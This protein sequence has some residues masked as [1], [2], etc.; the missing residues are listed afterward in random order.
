MKKALFVSNRLEQ[1]YPSQLQ[2]QVAELVDVIA[3]F[4]K[5]DI[6]DRAPELLSEVN[7][8]M[9]GWGAPHL[10][11]RFLDAAPNLEAF[12][13]AGGLFCPEVWPS[14]V[15]VCSAIHA[16]SIP[17]AEYT[18]AQIILSLKHVYPA[19]QALKETRA[20]TYSLDYVPGA[21]G[22]RVGLIG[23]GNIARLLID[24]LKN[25]D[26][27][28]AAYDPGLPSDE[29]QRLGVEEMSLNEIFRECDVVSLHA[30]VLETTKGMITGALIE[31]M[32]NGA[33]FINTAKGILIREEELAN[34][35]RKRTDL[36]AILDVTN[37]EPP[38][39]SSPLWHLPN[40]LLT[41]HIAGSHGHERHR[42]GQCMVDDLR[43]FITGRP[44][45]YELKPGS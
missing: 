7:V 9:S 42:V 18:L 33:T 26:V 24:L 21:Y 34:A 5:A 22:S 11:Q 39:L 45:L 13:Y 44:L 4:Q 37:P 29:F 1:V 35:L 40:V 16:N 2:Q 15:V 10:D 17:V 20:K 3:P 23:L 12:F 38:E 8:I 27:T 36:F 19:V 28:I 43:N 14:K 25:I 30:P 32:K 31:N 6:L 41:P